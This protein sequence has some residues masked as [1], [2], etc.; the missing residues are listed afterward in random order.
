[1][2]D[3]ETA[4]PGISSD[5]LFGMDAAAAREY[6]TGFISALKLTEKKLLELGEERKKWEDRAVLARSRGAG[7]LAGEA[8]KEAGK[9]REREAALEGER[10]EL[11][12]QIAR[13][14]AQLPGL[15]A[16]QRTVD[17]DL[18]EQELLMAAGYAPGDEEKAGTERALEKLGN[19][20]RADAAL[21]ALKA[22]MGRQ[23]PEN[24]EERGKND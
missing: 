7:E 22:R 23:P 18:L 4:G 9:V 20:A 12:A 2:V 10:G 11:E 3:G 17:P 13:M 6:I 19:E 8:E 1:M 15:A 16:R 14:K 24:G 21:E 5:S